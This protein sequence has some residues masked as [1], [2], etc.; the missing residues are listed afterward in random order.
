MKCLNI[1]TTNAEI[2]QRTQH[3]R[4]DMQQK[5]PQVYTGDKAPYKLQLH[6]SQV[7]V[8]FSL[9]NFWNSIGKM[10]WLPFNRKQSSISRQR[11]AA[12]TERRARE[13]TELMEAGGRDRSV[14]ARQA[15]ANVST[16][17][18]N[19]QIVIKQPAP[20]DF[21]VTPGRVD[22]NMPNGDPEIRVEPGTTSYHYN[23]GKAETYLKQKQ[24][25]RMWVTEGKYDIYA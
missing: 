19:R 23:P 18:D 12:G 25:I 22:V 16:I 15:L 4:F 9:D 1:R 8:E 24:S 7:K 11:A 21:R 6:T 17:P 14:F 20:P 10:D 5:Q 3:G 2:G 13:G